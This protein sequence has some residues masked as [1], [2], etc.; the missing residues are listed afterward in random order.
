MACTELK[1][2]QEMLANEHVQTAASSLGVDITSLSSTL[3][4]VTNDL[5]GALENVIKSAQDS[6][7]GVHGGVLPYEID[8]Y[9]SSYYMDDANVPSLL[10][11]PVLGYMASSNAVYQS[12]REYVLSS[13]NPFYF[14]GTEGFGVG[15]PHEGYGMA[16]PMAIVTQA[17]TSDNDEEVGWGGVGG[18]YTYPNPNC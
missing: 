8:G 15:G 1:H 4:V 18:Q 14:K 3:A 2:L 11:L 6:P 16:W 10:S 12:T 17:M 9:D 13:R 5:C 7:S